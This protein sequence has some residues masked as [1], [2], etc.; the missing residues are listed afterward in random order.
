[1]TCG[2]C[3]R[4]IK[5]AVIENVPEVAN[6]DVNREEGYATIK[7]KKVQNCDMPLT[8]NIKNNVL[9]SIHVLVNGKFKASF[10]TGRKLST[11]LLLKP[12]ISSVVYLSHYILRQ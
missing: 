7:L 1:M 4:L 3:E 10:E 6:I 2:K 11:I 5:E 12:I 9:S 8:E